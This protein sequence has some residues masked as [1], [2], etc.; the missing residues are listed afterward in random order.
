MNR[1]PIAKWVVIS[2][3]LSTCIAMNSLMGIYSKLNLIKLMQVIPLSSNA[4]GY[5]SRI[6]IYLL[7][8]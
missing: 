6:I 4:L 1:F 5:S 7:A 3:L 2:L 8:L